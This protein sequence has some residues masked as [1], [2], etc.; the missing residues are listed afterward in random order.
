MGMPAPVFDPRAVVEG[1]APGR[2]RVGAIAGI[3]VAAL[4]VILV[5]GIELA[6][7]KASGHSAAPF[8]IALPLALAPVP[9][10]VSVVLFID[11]LEP[12]PR[13]NLIFGFLWGAGIAALA[14]IIINTAGLEYITQP[15]LGASAGQYVSATAGAPVVE[16]TLKGLFLVWLVRW[17]RQELDGPTD[18]I[19]YAAMVGLGFAMTENIGYYINAL[20][21]PVHGGAE[22][23]GYTFVLRGVLS[24]FLH[25]IFTSM[26][27]IGAAYAA[28]H[29][30]RGWALPLGWVAA[31]CLH[32]LWNGLSIFG[33]AGT[34]VAYVF[35]LGLLIV[36]YQV[37]RA[38]R[39]HIVGEI[40]HY[41][42]G[43]E[44]TG[45]ITGSDIAM[46][47]SLKDRRR[48]RTW[49]RSTGGMAAARAMSDYQLA[50]TE[51]ALL[52]QKASRGV[53]SRRQFAQSQQALLSLMQQARGEFLRRQPAP[54]PTPWTGRDTSAFTQPMS[55]RAT[56]PPPVMPRE[57]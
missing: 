23:L 55:Y 34:L 49:A 44:G 6:E 14:A 26:T 3:I 46:L 12:E 28:S 48:A 13:V 37:I 52:H 11:R 30:N 47:S 4:C 15:A 57:R 19:V 24:P 9:L 43:Y 5:F 53:V 41:L 16:E 36:L 8:F 17:R 32:A 31:M 39:R 38:D 7:A 42:P 33:L 10:L 56:V 51:L 50:T 25:P 2:A 20:V 45:L 22:L 29:R 18:G 27:G 1:R 35:L 40:R 21:N 54:P